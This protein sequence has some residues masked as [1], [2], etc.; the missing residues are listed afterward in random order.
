MRRKTKRDTFGTRSSAAAADA[1]TI[2]KLMG[3]SS[4]AVS[5][6]RV[7]PSLESVEGAGVRLQALDWQGCRAGANSPQIQPT[8]GKSGECKRKA[9]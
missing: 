6:R 8:V 4:V 7:H 2:M 9:V 1:S 5:Q 3:S